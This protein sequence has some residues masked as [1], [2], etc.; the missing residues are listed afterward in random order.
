M[1]K[2]ENRRHTALRAPQ[3]QGDSSFPEQRENHNLSNTYAHLSPSRQT[4]IPTRQN[5]L[6]ALGMHTPHTKPRAARCS[7]GITEQTM[8]AATLRLNT[9]PTFTP[10]VWGQPQ[11]TEAEHS[12]ERGL[13]L[14]WRSLQPSPGPCCPEAKTTPSPPLCSSPPLQ[15]PQPPALCLGLR[16]PGRVVPACSKARLPRGKPGCAL[17]H[18]PGSES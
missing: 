2:P 4:V 15:V 7:P 11:M 17:P 1:G 6:Y 8:H 9:A 16:V 18:R 10:C 14:R 3:T 12:P 13:V 5:P